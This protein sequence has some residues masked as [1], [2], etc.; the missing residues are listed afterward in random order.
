MP[1]YRKSMLLFQEKAKNLRLGFVPGLIR[2]FYHGAKKNR[3]YHERNDILLKY[4]YSPEKHIIRD[5]MGIIIPSENFPQEFK[6][7]IMNYFLERKEDE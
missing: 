4:N 5:P 6:D 7:D 2:H 1:E 3:Y